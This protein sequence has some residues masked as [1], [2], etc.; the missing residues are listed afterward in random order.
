MDADDKVPKGSSIKY[1]IAKAKKQVKIPTGLVGK[2]MDE[3]QKKLKDKKLEAEI[4]YKSFP[5]YEYGVVVEVEGEGTEVSEGSSVKVYVSN[6]RDD[7]P[8]SEGAGNGATTGT[9]TGGNN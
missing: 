5:G 9:N 2:N 6:W 4:V 3:V 1:V 8:E 7:S